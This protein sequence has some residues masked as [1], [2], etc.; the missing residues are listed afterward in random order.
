[1]KVL[2][3]D[4]DYASRLGLKTILVELGYEIITVTDGTQALRSIQTEQPDLAVLDWVMPG[5]D[6]VQLCRKIREEPE[7][8]YIYIIMLTSKVKNQDV[9]TALDAGADDFL[10]KPF[11]NEMLRSR[12]A[13]GRRIVQYEN[14]LV[15]K[16]DQLQ[17]YISEMEALAEHRSKQLIHAERM[18]TVGLL[19]AGIAHEINNP[20]TFISGNIQMLKTFWNDVEPWLR[21]DR[22]ND[23]PA[24]EKLEFI[25][26]EMPK[27]I[28]GICDGVNRVSTIVKGLKAFCRKEQG[29]KNSC[30]I[31]ACIERSLQFCHNVLKYHVD[32]RTELDEQLMHVA[33]DSQQM[34]QVVVN[35]LTNAADA[36]QEKGNGI[37]KIATQNMGDDVVITVEDNGPGIPEDTL[38]DIWQPFFTSKPPGKGTGLGLSTVLGIVEDHQGQITVQNK[39]EGGAL[40][41]VIIPV[42]SQ[43]ERQ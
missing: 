18:A 30:D 36:M 19:S 41:T 21:P 13:V 2:V 37:L 28:E 4:D 40:F 20:T 12:M 6:G 17:R 22:A 34:E 31:N 25:L 42:E 1:M 16:N 23:K 7:G 14:L 9:I 27:T 11:D 24:L 5:L 29:S 26:D 43:G 10:F 8:G 32:V 35:L 38:D 15:E 39:S 33:A 3:A